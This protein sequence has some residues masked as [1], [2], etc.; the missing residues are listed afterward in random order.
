MK[1]EFE[2]AYLKSIRKAKLSLGFS[3]LHVL[4]TPTHKLSSFVIRQYAVELHDPLGGTNN[5]LIPSIIKVRIIGHVNDAVKM[6]SGV[7]AY[8]VLI[9][10]LLFIRLS[11]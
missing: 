5:A 8:D 2:S 6:E 9:S 11:L 3:S 4:S 1:N 7:A 10:S